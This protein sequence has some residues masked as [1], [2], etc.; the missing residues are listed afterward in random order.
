LAVAGLAVVD[1]AAR[2][3]AGGLVGIGLGRD[4]LRPVVRRH[5]LRVVFLR[6]RIVVQER[7][8]RDRFAIRSARDDLERIETEV[9]AFF[10]H[11]AVGAFFAVRQRVRDHEAVAADPARILERAAQERRPQVDVRRQ[12]DD[13]TRLL[14]V[15]A[16]VLEPA[17]R[18]APGVA[19]DLVRDDGDQA[20]V[21]HRGD[22]EKLRSCGPNMWNVPLPSG[23]VEN[24]GKRFV[25]P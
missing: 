16:R 1:A 12:G 6:A 17:E 23:R 10:V 2:E 14:G 3:L 15:A 11:L 20:A 7:Q 22:M 5:E 21:R 18:Q 9:G 24:I 25:V 19:V 13:L 4:L 8:V